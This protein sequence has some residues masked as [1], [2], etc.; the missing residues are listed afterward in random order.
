[1]AKQSRTKVWMQVKKKPPKPS[2]PNQ[3]KDILTYKANEQ[4]ETLLKP[5]YIKAPPENPDIN[6]IVD[7]W[8]KW[9]HSYFYFG[10]TYASPGPD[11]ISSTFELKFARMAYIGEQ[12]FN[13]AYMRHTGHWNEIFHNLAV[14][15][16]LTAIKDEPYFLHRWRASNNFESKWLF[17]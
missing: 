17:V 1:M 2:V 6:Y 8:T 16:C 4:V 15:E 12:R 3:L 13:L 14:E 5:I 7:I 10:C 9:H 11:A